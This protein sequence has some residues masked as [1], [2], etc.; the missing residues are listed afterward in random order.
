[1]AIAHT[2][3]AEKASCSPEERRRPA[4]GFRS[5]FKCRNF[6]GICARLEPPLWNRNTDN[7]RIRPYRRVRELAGTT[8]YAAVRKEHA[9]VERKIA[10]LTRNHGARHALYHGLDKLQIQMTLTALAVNFKRIARLLPLQFAKHSI[11]PP[12]CAAGRTLNTG[13]QP[14]AP[15]AGSPGQPP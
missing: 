14:A 4:T 6:R 1:M 13:R 12:V 9:K 7:T 11:S 10:E 15:L 5:S 3:R 8:R 2:A